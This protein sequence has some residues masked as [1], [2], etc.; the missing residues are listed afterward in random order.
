MERFS[1][2]VRTEGR[3]LGGIVKGSRC[4]G[5]QLYPVGETFEMSHEHEALDTFI[6]T[7]YLPGR[8]FPILCFFMLCFSRLESFLLCKASPLIWFC[9]SSSLFQ[10]SMFCIQKLM[11]ASFLWSFLGLTS[12]PQDID[13]YEGQENTLEVCFC[14]SLSACQS[15]DVFKSIFRSIDHVKSIWEDE[16][17]LDPYSSLVF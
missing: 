7:L 8:P 15:Q 16:G 13:S 12:L 4:H 2:L 17:H 1:M 14:I 6:Y 3:G 5:F 9:M 11:T 10:I